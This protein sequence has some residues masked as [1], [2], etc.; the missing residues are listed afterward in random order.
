MD[1]QML[2]YLGILGVLLVIMILFFL[3]TNAG[4]QK[5]EYREMEVQLVKA[6]RKYAADNPKI[7]PTAENSSQTISAKVLTNLGY[8]DDLSSYAKDETN[9]SG[10]VE[11]YQT[12]S[13]VY[14]YVP[15]LNCGKYFS[16]VK[17]STKIINDYMGGTTQGPGLY[18]R[19]D[20]KFLTDENDIDRLPADEYVFRGDG[21]KNYIKVEDTLWRI[22]AIDA[23]GN[24][25]AILVDELKN[26]TSW[27]N[28]YNVETSRYDGVNEYEMNG[29]K[30]RAMQAAENVFNEKVALLDKLYSSRIKYMVSQM[31]LCVG[32]RGSKQEGNDGSIECK[33]VLE[34]QFSALLPAYYFMSASLDENCTKTTSKSCGNYNYLASIGNSW[35]TSTGNADNTSEAF[36]VN[37][38][39]LKSQTCSYTDDIKPIVMFG[40]RS[41]Y[42]KGSGSKDD[43]YIIRYIPKS[44]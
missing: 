39:A 2:K 13:G 34:G 9:C 23:D 37:S 27:D 11:I 35:W 21:V 3:V 16:S 19:Y 33:E 28:R 44:A 17:L 12:V 10:G 18:A 31:D 15:T 43:P 30:S 29:I 24:I 6:A 42:S 4:G 38:R 1:K 22:V 32:K 25:I 8:I 41:V 36:V 20:G 5:Y 40:S 7:L 26:N 14:N